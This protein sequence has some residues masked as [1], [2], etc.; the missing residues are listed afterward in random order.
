MMLDMSVRNAML[1]LHRPGE[2]TARRL[3]RRADFVH[4]RKS[5]MRRHIHLKR[6][7]REGRKITLGPLVSGKSD[8]HN[9]T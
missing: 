4:K 1:E 8:L 3:R 9:N 7:Q 5:R 6:R 2:N